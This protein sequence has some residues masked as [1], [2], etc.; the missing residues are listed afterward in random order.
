MQLG[1]KKDRFAYK[2]KVA[3]RSF[4]VAESS[5]GASAAQHQKGRF[6]ALAGFQRAAALGAPLVTF[7]ATGK[8]PGCRAERLHWWVLGLPAPHKLP[9]GAGRSA[10]SWGAV[11]AQPPLWGAG[12]K[13]DDLLPRGLCP[14]AKRLG[15]PTHPSVERKNYS[16][17]KYAAP[18]TSASC[19]RH[20]FQ[21]GKNR[22]TSR[23]KA[24]L[25]S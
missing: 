12:A 1:E 17:K 19:R 3:N 2:L 6:F 16:S 24:A 15:C 18:A 13:S 22:S 23:Q 11:G 14:L 7:P 9:R 5:P 25:W 20:S 8:S 21:S 4:V 10:R